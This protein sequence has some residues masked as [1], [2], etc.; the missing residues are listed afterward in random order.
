MLPDIERTTINQLYEDEAR[1]GQV[2][3]TLR[4][5]KVGLQQMPAYDTTLL[6]MALMFCFIVRNFFSERKSNTNKQLDIQK[7][8]Q[9]GL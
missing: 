9:S 6:Q 4:D 1:K 2:A 3:T 8:S 5:F 7:Q